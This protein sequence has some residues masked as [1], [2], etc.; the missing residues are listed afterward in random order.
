MTYSLKKGTPMST[1]TTMKRAVHAIMTG[2]ITTT[3]GMVAPVTIITKSKGL[4]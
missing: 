1:I 3:M 4:P 2:N